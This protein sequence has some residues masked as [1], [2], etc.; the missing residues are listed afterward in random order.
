MIKC[1]KHENFNN[2]I[3]ILGDSINLEQTH[4]FQS[5]VCF[6]MFRM[7]VPMYVQFRNFRYFANYLT[8]L[9]PH[10]QSDQI[11][12]VFVWGSIQYIDEWLA[13]P[14]ASVKMECHDYLWA[15]QSFPSH[16]EDR[17]SPVSIV[18]HCIWVFQ[19]LKTAFHVGRK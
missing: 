13:C 7:F 18:I 2:V 12:H 9:T 1:R 6:I 10:L 11:T 8:S 3:N 16:S 5:Y 14:K 19:S 15:G 17:A 4:H